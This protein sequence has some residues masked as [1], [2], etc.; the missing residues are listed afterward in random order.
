[1]ID[2][3]ERAPD[4]W[5]IV[6]AAGSPPSICF[7]YGARSSETHLLAMGAHF[8]VVYSPNLNV[9]PQSPL[10]PWYY[11]VFEVCLYQFR[12]TR[13]LERSYRQIKRRQL[14]RFEVPHFE[15]LWVDILMMGRKTG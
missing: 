8:G 15:G 6:E 10:R 12:P 9:H 14:T 3:I 5:Q 1:M 4:G 11:V 13:P 2:L 7:Y